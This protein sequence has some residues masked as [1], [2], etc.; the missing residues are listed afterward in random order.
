MLSKV[1]PFDHPPSYSLLP[2]LLRGSEMGVFRLDEYIRANKNKGNY[3]VAFEVAEQFS[4][5]ICFVTFC[6]F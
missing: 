3:F 5:E 2:P 6:Y 4:A 1:F